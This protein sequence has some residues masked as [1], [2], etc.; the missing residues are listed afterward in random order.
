[1][2]LILL[3][4]YGFARND[5]IHRRL[6]NRYGTLDNWVKEFIGAKSFECFSRGIITFININICYICE[7]RRIPLSRL[8]LVSVIEDRKKNL[9]FI[10]A[11]RSFMPSGSLRDLLNFSRTNERSPRRV[12]SSVVILHISFYDYARH[13]FLYGMNLRQRDESI[14][15]LR[16]FACHPFFPPRV[17][18]NLIG[19]KRKFLKCS[20]FLYKR[21]PIDQFSHK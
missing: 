7:R 14:F 13:F 1:M 3:F 16:F 12:I 6:R 10:F 21:I 8:C 17:Y 20:K 11:I 4:L 15:F 18:G 2:S 5:E 9:A 19:Q